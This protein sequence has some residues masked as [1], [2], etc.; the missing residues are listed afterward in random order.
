MVLE[1]KQ[2]LL[3]VT[4]TRELNAKVFAVLLIVFDCFGPIIR[5]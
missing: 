5:F 1:T 2:G 4:M 3:K